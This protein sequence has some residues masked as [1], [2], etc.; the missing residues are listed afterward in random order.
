M[1]IG[2]L[3]IGRN[4]L[5]MIIITPLTIRPLG[6]TTLLYADRQLARIRIEPGR[7]ARTSVA[8]FQRKL[9]TQ[10]RIRGNLQQ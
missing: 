5:C 1:M 10:T 3:A 9:T 2:W 7:T 4:R 6:A 8:N